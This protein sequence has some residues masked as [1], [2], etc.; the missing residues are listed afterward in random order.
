MRFCKREGQVCYYIIVMYSLPGCESINY[1]LYVP[2]RITIRLRC[3]QTIVPRQ[4]IELHVP[5]TICIGAK[6]GRVGPS[7]T[8]PPST[9]F[10]FFPFFFLLPLPPVHIMAEERQ[11][12]NVQEGADAPDVLP[13]SK[14]DRKTAAALSS[15][16]ANPSEDAKPKKE[17]DLK[18]LNEAMKNLDMNAAKK[19]NNN[20]SATSTTATK[21]EEAPKKLVKVDA[22]DVA[23]LV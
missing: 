22:A 13:A 11:P 10:P 17:T 9:F 1:R 3:N 16:D 5:G 20:T 15:L 4:A 23:M 6:Y 2:S 14:E 19:P 12:E 18:A 21:K 7:E 8:N